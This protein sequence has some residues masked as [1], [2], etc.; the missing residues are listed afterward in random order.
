MTPH[1]AWESIGGLIH[2]GDNAIAQTDAMQP[3]LDWLRVACTNTG[4]DIRSS[5]AEQASEL[6]SSARPF[7]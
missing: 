7:S 1:K 5:P 6:S 2:T 3:L 4:T